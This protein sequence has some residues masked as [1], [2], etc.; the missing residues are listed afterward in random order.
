MRTQT[1]S[2]E[3]IESRLS[4]LDCLRQA[5]R[6]AA[7]SRVASVI[8]HL[9]GT[10]LHVIAGRAALIRSDPSPDSVQ[11]NARRIEAQVER[12]AQ[13]IR[14]L[15]E[16]LTSPQ[17]DSEPQSVPDLIGEALSLYVP[18]AALRDIEIVSVG[19]PAQAVVQG[20]PALLILTS[21]F[22]LGVRV[23]APGA[24]I[25]LDCQSL[26]SSALA[27]ELS[28]PGVPAPKGSID[29]L[30]PPDDGVADAETLQVLSVCNAIARQYGGRLQ[31]GASAPDGMVIRFE[32]QT[33]SG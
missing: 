10:P 1:D 27:F 25:E 21:L 15:I 16:Y 29:H 20:T 3:A 33:L 24:R 18:I 13:R 22:S 30:D 6:R 12:L 7:I 14:K 11:E 17:L 28:I 26:P 4:R 5:E 23:V 31:L 32:C 19:A 2:S 9:I 8:A